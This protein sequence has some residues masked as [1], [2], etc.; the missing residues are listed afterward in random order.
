MTS[1]KNDFWDTISDTSVCMVT[2]NDDGLLR[3]RPMAP[4]IDASAKTIHFV[5]DSDSA[6]TFEIAADQDIGLSFMDGGKM[7]YVSV[8]A[9]GTVSRDPKLIKQ[10]WGPYCKVFFGDGPEGADVAVIRAEPVQ[11][12]IWDN[13]GSKL[14]IAAEMTR[15]Y[16]SEDG[17]DLGDNTKINFA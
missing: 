4:Y 6:K 15:A 16:F 8:S 1:D 11:A 2:T 3:S 10:L 9:K 12:E 17:P 14:A 7:V 13:S 5:T